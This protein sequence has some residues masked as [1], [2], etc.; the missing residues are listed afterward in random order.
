M[1]RSVRRA[2]EVLDLFSVE[3]PYWGPTEVAA[4]L[5]V[6]KSSAHALLGE[7]ARAGLTERLPCGRHRLGWRLVGLARTMLQ[8]SGYREM[9]APAARAL[10][11]HFGETVHVGAVERGNVV[12]VASERP[13]GGVA[14]PPAPVAA[15]L[16]PLGQVLLAQD[17]GVIIGP[18]RA[19]DGVECAAVGLRTGAAPPAAAIGLC[20]PSE[21]FASRGDVYARALAATSRRVSRGVRL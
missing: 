4:Q 2:A 15:A 17:A 5:G 8:T 14:A 3:R 1:P 11:A 7:L 10:A 19:M 12:Y 18:Q 9:V 20:A 16:T 13:P 6:A 21:R